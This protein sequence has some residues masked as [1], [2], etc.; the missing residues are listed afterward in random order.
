MYCPSRLVTDICTA[1]P[2][3]YSVLDLVVLQYLR[4]PVL[5]PVL[6]SQ[7]LWGSR[8][9]VRKEVG[10]RCDRY[11]RVVVTVHPYGEELVGPQGWSHKAR[12]C[13]PVA[14]LS[15]V[16]ALGY[17]TSQATWS[18]RKWHIHSGSQSRFSPTP[19]PYH[20]ILSTLTAQVGSGCLPRHLLH[21]GL[22][23]R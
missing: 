3:P 4:C 18:N 21:L 8:D 5:R 7:Q 19:I 9:L 14:G 23:W 22:F 6:I 15:R 10:E 2:V 20:G 11:R 16:W 13:P 1:V 12:G 17:T